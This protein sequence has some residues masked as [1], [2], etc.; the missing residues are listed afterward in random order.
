ELLDGVAAAALDV[1]LPAA[2]R[3]SAA[4]LVLAATEE[5]AVAAV[6]RGGAEDHLVLRAAHLD[7][8][9][10]VAL[11]TEAE[12]LVL[13]AARRDVDAV[14]PVHAGP[15]V[16][17][18]VLVGA[19][20]EAVARVVRRGAAGDAVLVAARDVDAVVGGGS[21]R[22]ALHAVLAVAGEADAVRAAG[23]GAVH[24]LR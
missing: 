8:A 17:P 12:E 16:R 7:A 6:L 15:V 5:E 4:H 1:G 21:Y 13:V 22:D 9:V 2:A 20:V 11:G 3:H 10:G 23:D 14:L 18:L 24:E 19:H